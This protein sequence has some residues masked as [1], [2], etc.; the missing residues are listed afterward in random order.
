MTGG[1]R[2]PQSSPPTPSPWPG[3]GQGPLLPGLGGAV[4]PQA[5]GF[6]SLC[7]GPKF[8]IWEKRRRKAHM[9]FRIQGQETQLPGAEFDAPPPKKKG[10]GPAGFTGAFVHS[11]QIPDS[12]PLLGPAPHS[13]PASLPP[14]PHAP[15]SQ[16]TFLCLEYTTLIPT[17]GPL[18]VPD[19]AWKA[20]PLH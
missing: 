20:L 17:P 11:S 14:L 16:L 3:S 1:L 2:R 12:L 4:F 7:L 10:S 8:E 19:S 6:L 9:G 5:G 18:H 13:Y 15:P